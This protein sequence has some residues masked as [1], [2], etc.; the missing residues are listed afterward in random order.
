MRTSFLIVNHYA[1]RK[2]W[3]YAQRKDWRRR[4]CLAGCFND[5]ITR[6]LVMPESLG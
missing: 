3:H 5:W 1:Q 4:W 6:L 2:N